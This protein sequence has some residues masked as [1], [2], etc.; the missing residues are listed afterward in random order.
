MAD[1]DAQVLRCYQRAFVQSPAAQRDDAF[2]T[3]ADGLFG[4]P[5]AR[6]RSPFFD[7]VECSQGDEAVAAARRHSVANRRSTRWSSTCAEVRKVA[8]IHVSGPEQRRL[9]IEVLH[10]LDSD[11]A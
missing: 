1:D 11:V 9:L 3:L 10:Q 2:E 7:V 6:E 5:V 8:V 4:S